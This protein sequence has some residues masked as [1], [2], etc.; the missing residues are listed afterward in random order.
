MPALLAAFLVG[1][2]KGGLPA[3]GGLAVPIMA[4]SA[5]PPIKAASLLLPVYVAS[6]V[7]GV[8]LYRRDYSRPNL[9]ILLPAGILGVAIGW[10]TA[11]WLSD[12]AASVLIGC[13]GLAFCVSMF[14]RRKRSAPPTPPSIVRGTFWGTLSGFTSFISHAG[15]PPFQIYVLPQQLPKLVFAGTSTITFAVINA[16]KIVPYASLR[17]YTAEDLETA[18]VLLPAALIGTVVGMWATRRIADVWFFRLVQVAL[19]GV[20]LMLVVEYGPVLWASIAARH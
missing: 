1:L 12:A 17:P 7:V 16:A 18:A 20:S 6:D 2:S 5:I 8:Y 11:A 15:G 10:A 4:L 14:L 3:I 19:F 9:K 13:I